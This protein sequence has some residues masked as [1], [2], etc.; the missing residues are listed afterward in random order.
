MAKFVGK[1]IRVKVGTADLTT[2]VASVEVT[3][4]V[5]EIET[6]AFNQNARSRVAGLKDASVTISFHQDY[7]SGKVAD[8]L[9]SVFGGTSNVIVLA[10]TTLNQ[11]TA[12]AAAPMFT[13]PVLCSQQTPVNGQVGDLTT[14]D[15][16]WPAVGEISK[17]TAG[18]F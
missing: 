13:I 17:S 2:Y 11:G 3:E 4:T 14:F 8:T 10:G 15:V 5:D 12:T 7:D 6:T 9:G 1:N 18:T 16:T